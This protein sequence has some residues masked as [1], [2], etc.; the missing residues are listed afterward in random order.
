MRQRLNNCQQPECY[1]SAWVCGIGTSLFLNPPAAYGHA[2][3]K[4]YLC[5]LAESIGTGLLTV[6]FIDVSYGIPCH[7]FWEIDHPKAHWTLS[8]LGF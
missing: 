4:G 2:P 8:S 1:G 5:L 6:T 7:L 3:P